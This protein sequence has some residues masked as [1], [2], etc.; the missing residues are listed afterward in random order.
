MFVYLGD[1]YS[2]S[3]Q[4]VDVSGWKNTSNVKDM[5]EMF[6]GCNKLTSLDVSSW[7]TSAVTDMSSD[8]IL[9]VSTLLCWRVTSTFL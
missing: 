2:D 3:L 5:S 6:Y 1:G 8:D 9:A 7:D 4:T